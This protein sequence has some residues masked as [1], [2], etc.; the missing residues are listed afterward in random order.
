[1]LPVYLDNFLRGEVKVTKVKHIRGD[2]WKFH[3]DLKK[4]L[5]E[6]EGKLIRSQILEGNCV[7]KFLGD[8]VYYCEQWLLSKGF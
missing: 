3:D 6:T 8:H 2:I 1:M 4:Y 5:E 7:I